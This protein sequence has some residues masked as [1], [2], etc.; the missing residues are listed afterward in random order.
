M[1]LKMLIATEVT[2]RLRSWLQIPLRILYS[3]ADFFST[4]LKRST[5]QL[6]FD[7]FALQSALVLRELLWLVVLVKLMSSE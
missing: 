1:T 2:D 3:F 6:F 4:E 7:F 5:A